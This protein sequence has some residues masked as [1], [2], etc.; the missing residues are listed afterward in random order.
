[1]RVQKTPGGLYADFWYYNYG[2]YSL[3][4]WVGMGWMNNRQTGGA[5]VRFLNSSG[6][7]IDCFESDPV[8]SGSYIDWTPVYFIQLSPSGC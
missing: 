4:N 3:E 8:F 5:T 6:G 7:L 1:M 2:V